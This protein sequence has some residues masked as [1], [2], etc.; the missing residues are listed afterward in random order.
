[1]G[2]V[3]GY[4]PGAGQSRTWIGTTND[5]KTFTH[6]SFL[7]DVNL[8]VPDNGITNF[9]IPTIFFQQFSQNSERLAIWQMNQI[10]RVCRPFKSVIWIVVPAFD[11]TRGDI[12]KDFVEQNLMHLSCLS[13]CWF[14]LAN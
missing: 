2:N 1:M 13:V 8:V 7:S 5:A 9:V 3:I 10:N 6:L 12:G 14:E 4:H 11:Q